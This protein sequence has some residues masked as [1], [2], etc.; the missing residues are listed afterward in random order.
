MLWTCIQI[1]SE[2]TLTKKKPF[3]RQNNFRA[4]EQ[5]GTLKSSSRQSGAHQTKSKWT[6]NQKHKPCV[7]RTP[8]WGDDADTLCHSW[9]T[10]QE[11]RVQQEVSVGPNEP[12]VKNML[13]LK[14]KDRNDSAHPE[15]N[16]QL[17][18]LKDWNTYLCLFHALNKV[19]SEGLF[20][21]FNG[22]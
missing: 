17:V 5:R 20:S 12:D 11:I 21:P 2:L 16:V 7:P 13:D 1:Y 19:F 3:L 14:P 6:T 10:E 9:N 15:Y 22:D 4:T 8:I 18:W